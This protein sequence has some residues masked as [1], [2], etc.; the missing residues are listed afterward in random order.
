M[1]KEHEPSIKR[2]VFLKL[3]AVAGLAGPA[4]LS[5]GCGSSGGGSS[6]ADGSKVVAY[7]L[8]RRGQEACSACRSHAENKLFLTR[9]YADGNR[10]HAGCNCSIKTVWIPRER[11][12]QYFA[13]GP[14]YDRRRQV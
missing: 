13:G 10:A 6:S 9:D 3:M 14:V 7:K 8:S 1:M 2:R 11:H 12:L 4:A 5:S